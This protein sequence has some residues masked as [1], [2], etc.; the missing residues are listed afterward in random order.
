MIWQMEVY[1]LRH[2]A[3]TLSKFDVIWYAI[4]FYL[5]EFNVSLTLLK[6]DSSMCISYIIIYYTSGQLLTI[7]NTEI[8][9]NKRIKSKIVIYEV[10]V[11]YT[12]FCTHVNSYLT[13]CYLTPPAKEIAIVLTTHVHPLLDTITHNVNFRRTPKCDWFSDI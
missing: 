13:K 12:M 1:F 5:F 3:T 2:K 4:N 11:T 8:L 9:R 6:I 10:C 7:H